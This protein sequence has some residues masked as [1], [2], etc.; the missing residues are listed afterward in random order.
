MNDE[1]IFE[2]FQNKANRDAVMANTNNEKAGDIL[3]I[4]ALRAAPEASEVEYGEQQGGMWF[5]GWKLGLCTMHGIRL[6]ESRGGE[7]VIKGVEGMSTDQLDQFI[8]WVEKLQ[9]THIQIPIGVDNWQTSEQDLQDLLMSDH[10]TI[11]EFG[12]PNGVGG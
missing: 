1:Q 3:D 10:D 9:K 5:N 11:M 4:A 8:G 7:I 2:H 12:H 6:W